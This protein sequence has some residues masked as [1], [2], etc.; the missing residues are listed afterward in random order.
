VIV[1]L[2]VWYFAYK[3]AWVN[4]LLL[5]VFALGIVAAAVKVYTM[6]TP[7]MRATLA[8]LFGVFGL[9]SL[10]WVAYEHNDSI[11]VFFARDYMSH[12]E[13]AFTVPDWLPSWLG[14]GTR[15]EPKADAYQFINSL[16]VLIFIPLFNLGF[17]LVDPVA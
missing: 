5:G 3:F 14:G 4:G 16:F 8:R 10:W 15:Y 2:L 13:T 6:F 1:S 11:W 12:A 7:E 17:R 9:I